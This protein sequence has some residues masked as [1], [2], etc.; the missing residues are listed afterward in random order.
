MCI[1]TKNLGGGLFRSNVGELYSQTELQKEQNSETELKKKQNSEEEGP[2]TEDLIP[3]SRGKV[4]C[5]LIE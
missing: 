1:Y 5:T 2:Y 4:Y 3:M